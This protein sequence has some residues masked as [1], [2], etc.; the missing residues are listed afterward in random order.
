M[1]LG[2]VL[3][4]TGKSVLGFANKNSHIISGCAAIAGV[5][6]TAILAYK[7][8][9]K[10][11]RIIEEQKE[12]MEELDE[13]VNIPE[14]ELKRCRREITVDTCKSLAPALAPAV[15]SGIATCS[16]MGFSII[17][18]NKKIAAAT[19]LAALYETANREILN[20]TKELVGEEKAE[21][22]KKAADQEVTEKRFAD[23][24]D[25]DLENLEFRTYGGSDWY[26]DACTGRIFQCD[27]GTIINLATKLERDLNSGRE[28]YIEYGGDFYYELGVKGGIFNIPYAW[29]EGQRIEP[30]L[31]NTMKIGKKSV[32]ILDWIDRPYDM[33]TVRKALK[34]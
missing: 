29:M 2:K 6:V 10:V 17:S 26:F 27:D 31:N 25:I 30:N 5:A 23:I 22:I 34:G 16:L 24:P 32:T 11:N 1:N 4:T 18:G 9:P 12:K 7:S 3:K 20:K 19:S 21:E 15:M 33:E 14:E 28:R 13:V 8:Y